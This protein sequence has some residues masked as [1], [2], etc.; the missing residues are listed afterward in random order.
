MSEPAV[1]DT[2]V[3]QRRLRFP[4]ATPALQG[5]Q[6]IAYL[7]WGVL[8]FP[9]YW[10]AGAASGVPGLRFRRRCF[11]AGMRLLFVRGH[12]ADAYRCIVAPMDSVRHFEMDFFWQRAKVL[13]PARVLDVS[14]PRLFTLLLLG[15]DRRMQ[16]DLLNPDKSDLARTRSLAQALR[17]GARC[18]F[19]GMRVDAIP[20]NE[21]PYSLVVCMSVL[22]HIVD[23]IEA[24]R[25]MWR[26]VAPGGR[27]LLS[28]PCARIP[29]DE[30]TNVDEYGLLEQDKDGFVFWQRYYDRVRLQLLFAVTGKPVSQ[31]IYAERNPGS[32]D[33][34]VYAKRTNPHYPCW[35]EPYSTAKAYVYRDDV[36]TLAGMGVIAMEFVKPTAAEE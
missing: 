24:L 32:Y 31:A 16:A 35:R 4:P 10:M 7:L 9:L 19:L 27:L 14:S 18:R 13:R 33:A 2:P 15:D 26:L 3:S 11:S 30:F 17:V 8:M 6:R 20:A 28:V 1:V 21:Q 36:T 25:I 12:L 23:D 22:E 5:R 29:V 34:D